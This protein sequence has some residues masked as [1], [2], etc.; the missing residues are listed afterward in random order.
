PCPSELVS[1]G[2]MRMITPVLRVWSPG[3]PN[4][5]TFQVRPICSVTVLGSFCPMSGSVTTTI[6]PPLFAR[7]SSMTRW[8]VWR[9]SAGMTFAK[10]LTYPCGSGSCSPCSCCSNTTAPSSRRTLCHIRWD[11]WREHGYLL[12]TNEKL[13]VPPPCCDAG[14]F[15]PMMRSWMHDS[16]AEA[17]APDQVRRVMS[18]PVT[19]PPP[20]S[21]TAT[22]TVPASD[23]LVL[24]PYS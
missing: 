19:S 21:V 8:M 9:L 24:S 12:K 11:G 17:P 4:L 15:H 3:L 2:T 16:A 18:A 23:G 7:T 5:P 14:N 10:S 1:L 6:S 22:V 20:V 13:Y